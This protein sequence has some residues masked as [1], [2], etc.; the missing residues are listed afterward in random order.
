M[1]ALKEHFPLP[2]VQTMTEP[3]TKPCP[4]CGGDGV[5]MWSEVAPS[6]FVPPSQFDICETCQ[7]TGQVPVEEKTDD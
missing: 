4:E 1:R 2:E 5:A 7:G 3:K 6:W